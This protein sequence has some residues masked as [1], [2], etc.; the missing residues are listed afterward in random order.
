[1][2][3]IDLEIF[4]W[5]FP[6]GVHTVWGIDPRIT[7]DAIARRVDLS[8]RAVWAR[9]RHWERVGFCGGT[10][11][12]PNPAIFGAG[13]FRAEVPAPGLPEAWG[14][15]EALDRIDG[16]TGATL[17]SGDSSEGAAVPQV[18]LRFVA[19][20]GAQATELMGRILTLRHCRKDVALRL[21]GPHVRPART[22]G[23]SDLA[24]PRGSLQPVLGCRR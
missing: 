6:G 12:V 21:E 4:R 22:D 2:D 9:R 24:E 11:A 16:I 3:A 5:M 14:F 20:T 13:L 8:R 19:E 15:L 1:M 17:H 23:P 7:N 10:V 18:L